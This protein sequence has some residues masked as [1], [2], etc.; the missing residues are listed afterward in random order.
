MPT[1]SL[2]FVL[3]ICSVFTLLGICCGAW[4]QDKGYERYFVDVGVGLISLS[5]FFWGIVVAHP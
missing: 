3:A 5:L 2:P 4:L 1:F